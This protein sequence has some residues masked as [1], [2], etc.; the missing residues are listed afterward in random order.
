MRAGTVVC[1]ESFSSVHV[2]EHHPLPL[3]LSLERLLGR[4]P[5]LSPRGC[6]TSGVCCTVCVSP[7]AV[8]PCQGS[9][10]A[11]PCAI[12]QP[13]PPACRPLMA[14]NPGAGALLKLGLQG[15]GG[16]GTRWAPVR[17]PLAAGTAIRAVTTAAQSQ[18]AQAPFSSVVP[19]K[20]G[21]ILLIRGCCV[22]TQG[23]R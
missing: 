14:G 18:S 23:K 5:F 16:K 6:L 15:T 7:S 11:G 9:P 21:E 8:P 17:T 12:P 1:G 4:M 2:A 10:T 19:L 13:Q 22:C 20:R 3:V